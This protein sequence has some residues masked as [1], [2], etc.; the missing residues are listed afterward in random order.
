[1]VSPVNIILPMLHTLSFILYQHCILSLVDSIIWYNTH[2]ILWHFASHNSY[3]FFFSWINVSAFCNILTQF[4][5]PLELVGLINPLNA[6][7]SPVCHLLA[8]LGVH[9]IFHVRLRVKMWLHETC[10]V[11]VGKHLFI[12]FPTCEIKRRFVTVYCQHS[13]NMPLGRS[14]YLVRK[15]L[16]N[17]KHRNFMIW[18]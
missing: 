10:E 7:S 1:L 3:H 15:W 13:F 11:W 6:E 8:L 12:T 16:W 17:K 14:V 9:H 5:L 2:K 4:W 18:P